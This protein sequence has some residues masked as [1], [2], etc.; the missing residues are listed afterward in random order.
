M[1]VKKKIK[2][3]R[4]R[5]KSAGRDPSSVK[6]SV[7]TRPIVAETES[8]AWDLAYSTLASVLDSGQKSMHGL[9]KER[10]ES[11]GSKRLVD[12]SE[13]G[14]ILDDRLYMPIAA[15]TGG[16]GNTTA[17]VGT[18]E[19]VVDSLMKYYKL[20]CTTILIRRFDPYNDAVYWGRH[21]VPMLQDEVRKY[22]RRNR[23]TTDV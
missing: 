6:F 13:R 8:E 17:L 7:S 2:D 3:F 20:G 18:A 23:V 22:L 16:A 10:L 19:Q 12:F 21:L 11:V 9:G 1:E 14:D 4:K 15:A 5:V